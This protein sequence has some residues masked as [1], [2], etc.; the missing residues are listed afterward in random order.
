VAVDGLAVALYF[1]TCN[2]SASASC[3]DAA[4]C[5]KQADF[6]TRDFSADVQGSGFMG[7]YSM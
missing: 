5:V 7:C 6:Q 4:D 1:I 2:V 3:Q